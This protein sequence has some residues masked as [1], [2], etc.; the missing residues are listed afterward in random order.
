MRRMKRRY[1]ALLPHIQRMSMHMETGRGADRQD[2]GAGVARLLNAMDLEE[3][4]A[5]MLNR[6]SLEE[7]LAAAREEF[8]KVKEGKALAQH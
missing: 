6:E 1:A 8:K 4:P 5:E 3:A 7:K 2:G